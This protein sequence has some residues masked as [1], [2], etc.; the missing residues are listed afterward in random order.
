LDIDF[1]NEI[2]RRGSNSVKH[3]GSA[4][5]FGT[6]DLLPLWVADMDFASPQ[7]VTRALAD[8][9]AHPLYGYTFYPESA[10]E[11]LIAWLKKRHH[12]EVQR[13]WIFM[14]P[15]VVPSLFASVLAFAKEGEGVIVQPPVY[16]P[17][18]SAVTTNRRRL[19]EN[20]LRQTGT[21]YEI[22]FE[23]LEK[24]AADGARLM[25]F[26]SPHNPVGRV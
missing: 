20:P 22:D 24:C 18:F 7:A 6:A 17:F 21:Q 1:D 23:H 3:D 8:R 15:G 9:A 26:C 4:A 11:S 25:L 13:E 19:I 12:W 5:Y 2:P 10:Y 16:F 14:A